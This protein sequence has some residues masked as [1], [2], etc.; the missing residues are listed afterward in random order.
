MRRN[1]RKVHTP[2]RRLLL[3]VDM[4]NGFLNPKG[5]L[6]CGEAGRRIIPFVRNRIRH[7]MRRGEPVAFIC[8]NHVPRDPEFKLF[9]PHCVRG[10]WESRLVPEMPMP[11][12]APV[13]PKQRRSLFYKT[14]LDSVLQQHKPD[15]VEVVGVCTN[16]CVYFGVADLT[17]RGY[18]VRVQQ[19]GVAS[20]DPKAHHFALEQMKSVFGAEII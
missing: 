17:V 19:K 13:I 8:D 12:D 18:R 6:Y 1:G 15:I 2:E 14:R 16:V 11:L 7:Y 4:L 5:S 10:T 20:F 3:V 9:S